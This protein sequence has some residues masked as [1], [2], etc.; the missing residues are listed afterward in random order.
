MQ[1]CKNTSNI[2]K[3]SLLVFFLLLYYLCYDVFIAE[4]AWTGK[5][6]LSHTWNIKCLMF[7]SQSDL[8][9]YKNR[10]VHF[11]TDNTTSLTFHKTLFISNVNR[12]SKKKHLYDFYKC[13]L[14]YWEYCVKYNACMYMHMWTGFCYKMR[15]LYTSKLVNFEIYAWCLNRYYVIEYLFTIKHLGC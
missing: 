15:S 10:H 7:V 2:L 1:S 3:M 8:R 13:T 14:I 5:N 4:Y 9:I 6:E 11:S 12:N